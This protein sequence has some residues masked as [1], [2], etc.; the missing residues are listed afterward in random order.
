MLNLHLPMD[1]LCPIV[2][3]FAWVAIANDTDGVLAMTRPTVLIP[4]INMAGLV[5]TEIHQTFKYPEVATLGIFEYM[6]LTLVGQVTHLHPDPSTSSLIQRSANI[7]T[8]RL[9]VVREVTRQRFNMR[10]LLC[11]ATF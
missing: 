7:S 3:V 5:P 10:R 1:H 11:F 8:L 4:G 6:K 2:P 9:S